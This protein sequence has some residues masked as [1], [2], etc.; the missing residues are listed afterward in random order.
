MTDPLKCT[1]LDL[2][3]LLKELETCGVEFEAGLATWPE[4]RKWF[5]R[6]H[7]RHHAHDIVSGYIRPLQA[8]GALKPGSRTH[9]AC[10]ALADEAQQRLDVAMKPF[11]KMEEKPKKGGAMHPE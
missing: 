3:R 1:R 5:W 2:E 4:Q 11:D 10:N 8:F 6:E 7:A 9:K